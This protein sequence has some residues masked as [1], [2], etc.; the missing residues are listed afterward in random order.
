MGKVFV[1]NLYYFR[2]R[3]RFSENISHAGSEVS[4]DVTGFNIRGNGDD[5]GD[6]VEL[7]NHRCS[8]TTIEFGHIYIHQ[9]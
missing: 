6:T 4:H 3:E 2:P 8:R 7:A 9:N 5:G 1:Q